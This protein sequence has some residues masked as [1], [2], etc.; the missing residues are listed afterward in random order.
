MFDLS[1]KKN[2]LFTLFFLALIWGSSYILM[3]KG[4]QSYNPTEI[5]LYRIFIVF[6]IFLPFGIKDIKESSLKI[7]I[8]ILV[9]AIIG[10]LIPY[11]LFVE[12]QSEIESSLNGVLNSTTPLFTLIFGVL[13]FKQRSNLKS[14][15]GVIIGFLAAAGLIF[16]S[17]KEINLNSKLLYALLPLLGSA[18]YAFNVN[19]IKNYL[20]E[21]SALK[22]TSWSFI[23]IGPPAG[24]ILFFNTNFVDNIIHN[25]PH[26]KNFACITILAIVGT[27]FAVWLFNLLVKKTSS[28]FASSVTYL[29][30][31]V[32]ILWGILDGEY[33]STTQWIFSFL[34]LASIS[35]LNS[36]KNNLKT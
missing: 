22:I 13:L 30:P 1:K 23:F 25:D 15:I 29:I 21:I 34:I 36:K 11:F 9:S 6:L 35:M 33:F 16:F 17:E 20:T 5:T 8:T 24:I 28:V 7:K 3:K 14:T 10:S 27:G 2:Q 19:L 26:L 12:A 32:A 18:C 31:I 4:L